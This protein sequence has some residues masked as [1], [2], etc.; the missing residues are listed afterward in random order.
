VA[1]TTAV[2]NQKLRERT[3]DNEHLI[4]GQSLPLWS[5][6]NKES[7]HGKQVLHQKKKTGGGVWATEDASRSREI[8]QVMPIT[9]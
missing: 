3:H 4:F 9:P 6:R 1:G 8:P 5:H 2:F 7:G